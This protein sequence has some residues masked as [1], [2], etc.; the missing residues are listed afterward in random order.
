MN[1]AAVCDKPW[2]ALDA[3]EAGWFEPG[4]YC[5]DGVGEQTY[6]PKIESDAEDD[7]SDDDTEKP[8]LLSLE[9]VQKYGRR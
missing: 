6:G 9:E 7:Q 1:E 8:L 5:N 3:A 4:I 2:W